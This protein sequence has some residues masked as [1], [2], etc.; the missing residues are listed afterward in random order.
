MP[1][2]LNINFEDIDEVKA[3][4][5]KWDSET[6]KWF[7]E[8]RSDYPNFK[9]WI[10]KDRDSTIILCDHYYIVEGK[11]SCFKCGKMTT[12]IGFGFENYY[13]VYNDSFERYSD[14]IHIASGIYSLSPKLVKYL[15]EKY[16]FYLG[17][18][19]TAENEYY[20]NHCKHC[21]VIQGN[22]FLFDEVDS[23][24]FIDSIEK[25][26]NLKLNKVILKNDIMIDACIGYG[27]KDSL[28]KKYGEINTI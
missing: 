27:S 7:I 20:S 13:E 2:L 9:K 12:V 28:I 22:F 4:G 21:N 18:S 8:Y 14:E 5:A 3:L 17:Y 23:P 24:F 16:N 19:K 15:K 25:A 6:K 11:Q 1:L 26:K 10:L